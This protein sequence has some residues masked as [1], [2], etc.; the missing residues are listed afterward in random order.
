MVL[1][2][3]TSLTHILKQNQYL[4]P[5]FT[6]ISYSVIKKKAISYYKEKQ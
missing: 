4:I 3:G 2:S 5:N 1:L 6:T